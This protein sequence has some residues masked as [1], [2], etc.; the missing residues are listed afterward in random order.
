MTTI[1]SNG[2]RVNI[3]PQIV[4]NK[5]Q[6][7]QKSLLLIILIVLTVTFGHTMPIESDSSQHGRNVEKGKGNIEKCNTLRTCQEYAHVLMNSIRHYQS[8]IRH[9]EM[10]HV[11]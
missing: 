2:N 1:R 3:T 7:V 9:L 11:L 8:R 6:L 4:C 10:A 5:M